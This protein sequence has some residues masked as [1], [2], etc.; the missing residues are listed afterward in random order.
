MHSCKRTVM[1][2]GVFPGRGSSAKVAGV[3]PLKTHLWQDRRVPQGA[4]VHYGRTGRERAH[5]EAQGTLRFVRKHTL[6]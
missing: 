5:Q 3:R 6:M 2:E 4:T 1:N